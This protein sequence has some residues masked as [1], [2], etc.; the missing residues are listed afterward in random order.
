MTPSEASPT[1]GQNRGSRH[2][3]TPTKTRT[4]TS[5]KN[6]RHRKQPENTQ[7]HAIRNIVLCIITS[8]MPVPFKLQ[9]HRFREASQ[10]VWKPAHLTS[11]GRQRRG[12]G[13]HIQRTA[14][15]PSCSPSIQTARNARPAVPARPPS[16]ERSPLTHLDVAPGHGQQVVGLWHFGRYCERKPGALLSV[17]GVPD[18]IS[19]SPLP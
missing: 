6:R 15:V 10:S 17:G 19:S 12:S 11:A 7:R 18:Q 4:R 9:G 13:V 8:R 3:I 16:R 5:V 1:S 14:S 2:T